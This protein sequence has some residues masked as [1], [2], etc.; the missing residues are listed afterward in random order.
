MRG[1][2]PVMPSTN[3]EN[4]ALHM[5]H[6]AST[7]PSYGTSAGSDPATPQ[8]LPPPPPPITE[9]KELGNMDSRTGTFTG[10]QKAPEFR[11]LGSDPS[12]WFSKK[13]VTPKPLAR[14]ASA[15]ATG[16][17]LAGLSA[18]SDAAN[19]YGYG[20]RRKRRSAKRTRQYKRR[21]HRARTR[22]AHKKRQARS[23]A[24]TKKAH[25]KRRARSLRK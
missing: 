17:A 7:G 14:R 20:G 1:V 8:M 4:S 16:H 6:A 25:K 3:M 15:V 21:R 22:K 12:E 5:S 19:R 10:Y 9:F 2:D 18:D 24:L 13:E 23:R 11:M